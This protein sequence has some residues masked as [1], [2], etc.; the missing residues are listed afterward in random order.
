[1]ERDAGM[2][3][4]VRWSQYRPAAVPAMWMRVQDIALD[5]RKPDAAAVQALEAF[6]P[7]YDAFDNS[8][9]DEAMLL[10][11]WRRTIRGLGDVAM[12]WRTEDAGVWQLPDAPIEFA[13]GYHQLQAELARVAYQGVRVTAEGLELVPVPQTL[14]AFLWLSAAQSVRDRHRFKRCERCNGWFGVQRADARF[15][16]AVCRNKRD[17]P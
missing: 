8:P 4:I 6:G 13:K 11:P 12:L 2:I 5:D 7:L 17:A 1:M 16:G 14:D 10:D 3:R 9:H 15:C